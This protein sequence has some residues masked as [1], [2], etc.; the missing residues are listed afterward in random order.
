MFE[1]SHESTS[2]GTGSG[3]GLEPPSGVAVD[4]KDFKQKRS[5][6][7][8]GEAVDRDIE[9]AFASGYACICRRGISTRGCCVRFFLVFHYFVCSSAAQDL[10]HHDTEGKQPADWT[11]PD[12]EVGHF[13]LA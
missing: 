8:A 9:M 7:D 6:G 5:K 12:A 11:A 1:G 10:T 2:E 3:L 13:Q 4:G